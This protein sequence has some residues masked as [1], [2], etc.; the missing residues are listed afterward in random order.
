ME[1]TEKKKL[2]WLFRQPEEILLE[3]IK[4]QRDLYFKLRA[5]QKDADP[6]RLTLQS[7]IQTAELLYAAENPT[8]TKNPEHDLEPLRRKVLDR[9]R[10][11]GIRHDEKVKAKRK[12]PPKK[13]N[14]IQALIEEVKIMR[15]QGQ[16]YTAIALYLQKYH[17]IKVHPS[18][19]SML[20]K[21]KTKVDG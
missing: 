11:H 20:L 8:Q 4:L 5:E 15:E 1:K 12:R 7:L 9:I 14:K 21:E 19:I 3:A 18:Y 16:S 10:R 2:M 6:N 17:R 13:K